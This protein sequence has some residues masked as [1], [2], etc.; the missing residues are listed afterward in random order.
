MR[1][2]DYDWMVAAETW[3][4]S[5]PSL[6][7]NSFLTVPLTGYLSGELSGTVAD[8]RWFATDEHWTLERIRGSIYLLCTEAMP[9]SAFEQQ[10]YLGIGLFE[11]NRT[12][13]LPVV[14]PLMDLSLPGEANRDWMWLDFYEHINLTTWWTDK[15]GYGVF[16][17][18]DVDIKARRRVEVPFAPCLFVQNLSFG[19]GGRLGV[20]PHLRTLGSKVS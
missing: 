19:T 11:L 17:R 13:G 15:P 16:T 4:P 14:N 7:P 9:A 8:A 12:T 1:Q 18:I 5:L 10:T 6:S 20:I 2:K 3:S